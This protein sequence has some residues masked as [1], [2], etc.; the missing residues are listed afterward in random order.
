M[1]IEKYLGRDLKD[2]QVRFRNGD[3]EDFSE[4]NLEAIPL[5]KASI[6]R[7]LAQLESRLADVQSMIDYYKKQLEGKP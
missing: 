4:E 1:L 7:R 3:I 2:E 6:R 5:G